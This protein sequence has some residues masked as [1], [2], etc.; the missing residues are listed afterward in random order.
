[1]NL[2]HTIDYLTKQNAFVNNQIFKQPISKI[3]TNQ[4]SYF[5]SNTMYE[6]REVSI[7]LQNAYI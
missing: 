7:L 5:T 2:L 1:M 3:T 4:S 6:K